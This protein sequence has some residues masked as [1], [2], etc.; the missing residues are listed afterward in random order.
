MTEDKIKAV[1]KRQAP[2][3][4]PNG[5]SAVESESLDPA[6]M[7]V[8]TSGAPFAKDRKVIPARVGEISKVN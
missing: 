8:S 4:E 7:A 6:N 2:K 1:L 3:M 5:M